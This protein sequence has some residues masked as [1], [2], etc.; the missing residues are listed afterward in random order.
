LS[1]HLIVG[2]AGREQSLAQGGYG[3]TLP[4]IISESGPRAA[5]RFIEFFTA[6]LPNSNTRA[7][8]ARAA[9]DFC[10]WCE[11]NRLDLV[12]ITPVT[13]AAYLE[14]HAGSAPTRKQH[15]A[16][17]RHSFAYLVVGHALEF[18]PAH[19]VCGSTP[20]SS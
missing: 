16:A 12:S 7:A 3:L 17:I 14:Q 13:M 20:V 19:A 18:N 9:R 2:G 8:Y 6:E 1:N 15:L 5:R 10:A 4:R 11:A